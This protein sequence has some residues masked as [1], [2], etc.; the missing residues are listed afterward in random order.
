MRK[1]II[2][3]LLILAVLFIVVGCAKAPETEVSAS[4]AQELETGIGE[5]S[6]VEQEMNTSELD[7]LDQE[8][9]DI[10]ALDIT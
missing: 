4:S 6:S 10:D 1:Q 8:L 3:L 7:S 9:A 5:I 2:A